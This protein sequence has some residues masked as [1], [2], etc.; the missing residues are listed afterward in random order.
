MPLVFF[1]APMKTSENPLV[2]WCF[3]GVSK[4]TSGMKWFNEKEQEEETVE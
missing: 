2:F 3:Q 4:E 1:I